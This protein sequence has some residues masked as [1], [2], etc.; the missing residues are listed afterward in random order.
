M[1]SPN[2]NA[3][4]LAP[5]SDSRKTLGSKL[6]HARSMFALSVTGGSFATLTHRL[7]METGTGVRWSSGGVSIERKRRKSG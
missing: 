2:V 3:S 4:N 6:F 1:Q 5:F 7:R